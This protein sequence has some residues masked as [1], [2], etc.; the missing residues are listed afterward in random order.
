MLVFLFSASNLLFGQCPPGF[1]TFA[2][3]SQIDNFAI[4]YPNCTEI[5]N[6]VIIEEATSGNI[7]NLNGLSQLTK[8]GTLRIQNNSALTNLNGLNNLTTITIYDSS[9]RL[10]IRNNQSLQNLDGLENLQE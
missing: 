1:I 8:V 6:S 7:T 3:Q 2:S 5:D 10:F 9:G 4:S